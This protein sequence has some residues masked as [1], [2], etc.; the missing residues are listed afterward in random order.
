MYSFHLSQAKEVNFSFL[1]K[2][3]LKKKNN[4]HFVD[5]TTTITA[6]ESKYW[7]NHFILYYNLMRRNVA[8]L[9]NNILE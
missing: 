7:R 4:S 8:S 3:I 1:K 6:N 9:E 2:E 5:C